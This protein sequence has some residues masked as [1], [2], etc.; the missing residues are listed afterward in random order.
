MLPTGHCSLQAK[1]PL[2]RIWK[3]RRHSVDQCRRYVQNTVFLFLFFPSLPNSPKVV[4]TVVHLV[5][6]P[7][8]ITLLYPPFCWT[9]CPITPHF[10]TFFIYYWTCREIFA[11]VR[12]VT[13]NQS[14]IYI[15]VCCLMF[16]LHLTLQNLSSL[17]TGNN[18]WIINIMFCW[19]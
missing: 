18:Y 16:I 1:Y 3:K 10:C 13:N 5:G 14:I 15:W 11:T 7:R 4:V 6:N 12:L 2:R 9:V 17:R 19:F 8:Q